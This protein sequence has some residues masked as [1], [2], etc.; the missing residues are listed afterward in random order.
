M[1]FTGRALYD[2]DVFEGVR[3][4]VSDMITMISPHETP[5]LN[6]LSQPQKPAT[7]V[8]HEWLE[9]S[10]A[11]NTLVASTA[12]STAGTGMAV[13]L[14]GNPVAPYLQVGAILQSKTTGEYLQI[15]AIS[16]NTLTVSRSFGGTTAGDSAAGEEFFVISDAA[17]EGADVTSDIS[18]ARTRHSN[19]CQIFKKDIIVSGTV[20]A[21]SHIG[22]NNEY[23]H[24]K[25]KR[26]KES[27]RDLEKAVIRGKTS[28]NTI[29]SES[30]YRTFKGLWDSLS[31]N[32]TSTGTLTPTVLDNIIQG[33][34]DQGGDNLNLI[35][36]D[37]NWKR[38]IDAFNSSRQRVIQNGSGENAF[39]QTITTYESTFGEQDVL[40]GRWMPANT[41]MVI[42]TG[43][44]HV[45]PLQGRSFTH[46]QVARTGDS[47]KGMVI[48]EY[49]LEVRAEEGM[50]K[51]YG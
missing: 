41:L 5:L 25:T 45:V 44:V 27:L 14:N 11:P 19:Y 50:A 42:D 32:A 34:W 1:P 7:N 12:I 21:V 35:V 46:Q 47:E 33:A 26:L 48:G 23:E 22:V 43:R 6:R 24:Q 20:Q 40:L 36:A 18:I 51:A 16:G 39:K 10:L 15:A 4:D 2:D 8:L 29:G 28:L 30:A 13:H 49:T 9:D 17:L 37:A 38:V 3:E 31:T